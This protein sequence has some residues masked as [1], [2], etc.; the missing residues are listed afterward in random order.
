MTDFALHHQSRTWN[1]MGDVLCVVPPD[2]LVVLAVRDQLTG[3]RTDAKLLLVRS[4]GSDRHMRRRPSTNFGHLSGCG[5]K[6]GYSVLHRSTNDAKTRLLAPFG[7]ESI[8]GG[9][10]A[11]SEQS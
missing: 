7:F 10:C 9:V 5:D 11:E 4:C 2:D 6:S 8:E 1:C 3:T